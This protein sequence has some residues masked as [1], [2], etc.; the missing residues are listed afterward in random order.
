MRILICTDG[1]KSAHNAMIFLSDLARLYEHTVVVLSVKSFGVD[2]EG[3][4]IEAK[5]FFTEKG[6]EVKT[7]EREGDAAEEILKESIEGNYDLIVLG[8]K[9]LSIPRTFFGSVSEKVLKHSK[10]P[11][12]VV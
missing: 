5:Q 3:A 8:A 6:V 10:I 7:I 1:S 9:G 4:L 12:L 2:S 11:V